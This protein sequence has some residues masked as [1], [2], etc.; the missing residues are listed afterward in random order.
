MLAALR[1]MFN[2]LQ[3]MAPILV[4]VHGVRLSVAMQGLTKPRSYFSKDFHSL[5]P[6]FL[7]L[8]HIG[9]HVNAPD[10]C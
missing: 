2:V 9:M 6:F 7:F 8:S 3:Y 5:H 10:L 1:D 4:R